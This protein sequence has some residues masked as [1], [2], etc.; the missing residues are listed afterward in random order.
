MCILVLLDGIFYKCQLGQN[1]WCC[2]LGQVFLYWFSFC[3]FDFSDIGKGI[4]ILP[5]L[6]VDYLFLLQF[7]Y[8][9]CLIYFDALWLGAY[10]FRII[11]FS[12]RI[13]PF[14]IIKCSIYPWLSSSL[15]SLL[16]LKL[17]QLLQLSI[18][19]NYLLLLD[20]KGFE[21]VDSVLAHFIF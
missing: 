4:C 3:L 19:V 11:V 15:W 2:H 7:C 17:I 18:Y 21:V 13:D 6:R 14:I 12:C 9:F 16:C 20:Y 10:M 5:T 8:F 1:D